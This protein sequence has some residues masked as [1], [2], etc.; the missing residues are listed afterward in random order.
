[1]QEQEQPEKGVI[2]ETGKGSSQELEMG[3]HRLTPCAFFY[4]G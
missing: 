2:T 4:E 1:M 3:H